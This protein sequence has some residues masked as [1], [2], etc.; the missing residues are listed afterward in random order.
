MYILHKEYHSLKEQVLISKSPKV[1][2]CRLNQT[3]EVL[4]KPSCIQDKQF[5]TNDLW[6]FP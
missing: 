2:S 4:N 3:T 1:G 6:N 5:K